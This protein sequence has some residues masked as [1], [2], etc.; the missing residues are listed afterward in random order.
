VGKESPHR[1]GSATTSDDTLPVAPGT[2]LRADARRNRE[3]IL[4][5]A[6]D[7]FI[8]Q[9]PGVPLDAVAT[10]A[11]VGNATLYRR[12]PDRE[13]LIRAVALDA[14]ARSAVEARAA[15][16]EETD[17]FRALARYMHRALDFRIAGVMST[18]GEETGV[19]DDE[20]LRLRNESALAMQRLIETAQ[21]QGL[22]RPDVSFGDIGLLLVRLSR[23]LPGSIPREVNDALGHRHLDFVLAG[24]RASPVT[25]DVRLSG[26]ALTLGDLRSLPARQAADRRLN[27]GDD[28]GTTDR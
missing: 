25:G 7:M 15:L 3:R 17:A 27:E 23:P 12:F 4:V 14:L 8:E 11:G 24:L 18:I 2:R 26:P 9:G 19:D 16:A 5:A 13:A 28:R 1:E 6:R 10:R 22:L 21:E 20:V